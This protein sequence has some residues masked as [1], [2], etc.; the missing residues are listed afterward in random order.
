MEAM[1]LQDARVYVGTYHKYACG[2]IEGKWL[3]MSDYADKGEFIQACKELHKDEAD[4]ELMFQDWENIP[5]GLISESS[6][7]EKFFELRDETENFSET[8][9]GAFYVW[10]NNGCYDISDY[11]A[12]DLV[13]KFED[14]YQGEYDSEKDFAEQLFEDCYASEIPDFAVRYFDYDAFARDLFMGDYRYDNGFVFRAA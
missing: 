6:I 12:Y 3:D 11:D 9:A 5:D 2:S 4:P 7:S 1:N 13:Q 10:L 8:E 14:E